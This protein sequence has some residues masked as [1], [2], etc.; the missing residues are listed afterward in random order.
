[1]GQDMPFGPKWAAGV[2]GHCSEAWAIALRLRV[3]ACRSWWKMSGSGEGRWKAVEGSEDVWKWV[4]DQEGVRRSQEGLGE[5]RKVQKRLGRP[6]ERAEE[7]GR[8]GK[9]MVHC[10]YGLQKFIIDYRDT[11]TILKVN[12]Q[13]VYPGPVARPE[14]WPGLDQTGLVATGP[15]VRSFQIL[16]WKTDTQPVFLTGC[17][18]TGCRPV[19]TGFAWLSDSPLNYLQN[20]P[21]DHKIW[22]K[23]E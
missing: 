6:W 20:E 8:H 15:V 23:I 19:P 1:M 14:K 17:K 3:K 7:A 5:I 13:L 10:I 18:K 9:V 16:N 22:M 4:G 11:S 2:L 12:I 21:K